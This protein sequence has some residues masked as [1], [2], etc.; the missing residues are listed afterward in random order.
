MKKILLAFLTCVIAISAC[1]AV[2]CS[3]GASW[4]KPTLTN[5]GSV[6]SHGGFLAET[7]NYVYVINGSGDSTADNAFGAP[8]KGSL[9]AIEKSSLGTDT[10]SVQVVVPKLFCA[11]DYTAG[12]YFYGGYVYYGS[13]STDKNSSGKVANDELAFMRTK[14][15]GTQEKSDIFF[16][17]PSLS[18]KYRITE[19]DGAVYI[20]YND[21]EDSSVK[22]YNTSDKSVKTL[23]KTDAENNTPVAEGKEIYESL[24]NISFADNGDL[25]SASLFYTAT[26]YN[27]KYYEDKAASEDYTRSTAKYNVVYGVNAK[28]EAVKVLD[29]ESGSITYE[30]KLIE[31]GYVFYTATPDG[32]TAKTYAK[33][34]SEMFGSAAATEIKNATYV[35]DGSVIVSLEEVYYLDTEA[36]T[37]IKSTLV[38]SET[39]VREKAAV[40]EN[41]SSLLFVDGDY[42]YF[43]NAGGEIARIKL[44]D[45]DANEERVSQG[46]VNASW[47]APERVTAGGKNYLFYLD[48]STIGSSYVWYTDLGVE[49][50]GEDTDDDDENDLFYL[51]GE[52]L[53]GI[54]LEADK[55]NAAI[56]A[57][58]NIESELDWEIKDGVFTVESVNKAEAIYNSLS[59][60]A[61]KSVDESYVTKLEN[62]KRAVTF[63]EKCYALKGVKNYN[64]LS[65]T[66]Q[67]DYRTKYEAV[68]AE[69]QALIK[70]LGASGYTTVRDMLD[71]ELKSYFSSA[72]SVIEDSND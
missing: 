30:I 40:S 14:L 54:M 28:G 60:E 65:E 3:D 37:V 17:V 31:S 69:K 22:V 47:Y 26:V 67:A 24:A 39:T 19:K 10:L 50:T 9:V 66:E 18:V 42:I 58:N 16:T 59:E 15:D 49:V 45:A 34:V 4:T 52:K 20:V 32:G 71:S 27:E 33:K 5:P 61:K 43:N 25:D 57:I 68:K 38:G 46:T 63:G 8:V 41:I 51:T 36:K 11:S 64:K 53:A 70:D 13:P 56:D 7:E 35:A 44:F 6:V 29:G 21:T 55:A 23:A 12:V 1:F 72:K 62:S 2:A 48:T